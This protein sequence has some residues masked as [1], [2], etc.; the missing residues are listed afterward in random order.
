MP[1]RLFELLGDRDAAR[2]AAVTTAMPAMDKIVVAD[3]EE[4]AGGCGGAGLSA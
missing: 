1:Q 4:A 3:L 2:A